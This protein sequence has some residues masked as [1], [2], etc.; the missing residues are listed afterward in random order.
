MLNLCH[1]RN[2]MA[3][4]STEGTGSNRGDRSAFKLM[5][6][7]LAVLL[8]P[9]L[10]LIAIIALDFTSVVGKTAGQVLLCM[11][12]SAYLARFIVRP[13]LSSRSARRDFNLLVELRWLAPTYLLI[14][15][16]VFATYISWR[17]EVI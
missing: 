2:K 1:K 7:T 10:L 4:G 16:A 15:T 9:A 8:V 6:L 11:F 13:I 3:S 17:Q 5:A 12:V 14:A